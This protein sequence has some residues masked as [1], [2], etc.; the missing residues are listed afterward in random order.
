[1]PLFCHLYH[2]E[3]EN[4][5]F[6]GCLWS[7]S[8]WIGRF[9]TENDFLPLLNCSLFWIQSSG[10]SKTKIKTKQKRQTWNQMSLSKSKQWKL[11]VSQE[12]YLIKTW[13]GFYDC[14]CDYSRYKLVHYKVYHPWLS[15]QHFFSL[16]LRETHWNLSIE[17][18][19]VTLTFCNI[20]QWSNGQLFSSSDG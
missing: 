5:I 18:V 7:S 6:S 19:E 9:Y 15:N 1:M 16:S 8:S 3:S 20:K 11:S 2:G 10:I 17:M 13:K 12:C 14:Q 4:N